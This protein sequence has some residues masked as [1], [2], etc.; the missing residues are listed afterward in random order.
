[1]GN[2]RHVNL[3]NCANKQGAK[4][5]ATPDGWKSPHTHIEHC[6]IGARMP[7]D[8]A[9]T[10]ANPCQHQ[11][12]HHP[13][14]SSLCPF[15]SRPGPNRPG[16]YP[17]CD[18]HKLTSTHPGKIGKHFLIIFSTTICFNTFSVVLFAWSR[19][20]ILWFCP[21]PVLPLHATLLLIVEQLIGGAVLELGWLIRLPAF[22][23]RSRIPE[24]SEVPL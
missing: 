13:T 5:E 3:P 16:T 22:P 7:P 20:R 19:G 9:Q 23:I 6:V 21:L 4:S 18:S 15:P 17:L 12:A 24:V 2:C 11:Q 10:N 8:V 14:K 1:M